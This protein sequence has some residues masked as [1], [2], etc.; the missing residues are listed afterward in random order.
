MKYLISMFMA[1]LAVGLCSLGCDKSC[2]EPYAVSTV[3]SF[4]GKDFVR[5][6]T[7]LPKEDGKLATGTT[8]D[9]G[10]EAF[11]ALIK[12]ESFSG[13]TKLFGKKYNSHY[14]PLVKN[15]ELVGAIFIG[16]HK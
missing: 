9:R 1:A 12:K 15:G 13:E 7:S 6:E 5:T 2:P 8:L 14:A 10:S 3:F 16:F 4:D 11:H